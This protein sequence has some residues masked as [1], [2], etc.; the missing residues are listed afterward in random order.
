VT[1][2]KREETEIPPVKVSEIN[3]EHQGGVLFLSIKTRVCIPGLPFPG[4]PEIPDIFH[5]RIPGNETDTIPENENSPGRD[6]Q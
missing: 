2:G 3:T 6:V 5:S 1:E 4:R